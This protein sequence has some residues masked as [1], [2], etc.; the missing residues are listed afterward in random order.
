MDGSSADQSPVTVLLQRMA[1]GEAAAAD[2]LFALLYDELRGRAR[3]CLGAQAGRTLQPTAMVHEVWLRLA[4]AD[5]PDFASRAHFFGVA[6]K[7]MRSI[8]VDHAR[9]SRAQKRGGAA[10]R[11]P[12]DEVVAQYEAR[13]EDLVELDGLLARLAGIDPRL[14]R[15]VELRFFA[16]LSIAA[17]AD[18]MGSSTA[19]VERGWRTARAWLRA[20]LDGRHADRAREL[21][22]GD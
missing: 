22:D 21:S 12:L 16:G 3:R 1:R 15:I 10:A 13:G 11:V 5:G 4:G 17:T 2:E 6:A 7:A 18:A 19:S 8:L 20:A 9:A 14:A